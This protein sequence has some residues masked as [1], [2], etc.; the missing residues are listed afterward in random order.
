M[1]MTSMV[2]REHLR[3]GADC[4]ADC[5]KSLKRVQKQ[6]EPL[7][8]QIVAE[9]DRLE[10]IQSALRCLATQVASGDTVST[11]GLPASLAKVVA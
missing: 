8:P 11:G 6:F 7:R 5:I 10:T 9:I 3:D 4:I 1:A 2:A